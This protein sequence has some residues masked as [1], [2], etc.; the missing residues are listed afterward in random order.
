MSNAHIMLLQ[1]FAVTC[2]GNTSKWCKKGR[3]NSKR[4]LLTSSMSVISSSTISALNSVKRSKIGFGSKAFLTKGCSRSWP[5]V[6]LWLGSLVRH[7]RMKSLNS[8]PI[9]SQVTR[10]TFAVNFSQWRCSFAKQQCQL[11]LL[12]E[13]HT[14]ELYEHRDKKVKIK[15]IF[16]VQT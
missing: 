11:V 8:L 10:D 12:I 15:S 7:I 5:A 9:I 16:S 1:I 3:N 14:I 6:G 4:I 2:D 13:R